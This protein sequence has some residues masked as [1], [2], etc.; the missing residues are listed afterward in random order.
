MKKMNHPSIVKLYEVIDDPEYDKL[1]MIMEYIPGGSLHSFIKTQGLTEDK[2][3]KYFRDII[4][5]LEYCH[6]AAE[7]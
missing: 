2:C 6:E 4:K 1:F 5:G 7:I 3:S